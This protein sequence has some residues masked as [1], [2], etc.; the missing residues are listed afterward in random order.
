[1]AEVGKRVSDGR[2]QKLIEAFLTANIMDGLAQWTPAP[3]APQGAVLS[4]LLSNIYLD[5]LDH[6]MAAAGAEMVRYA[7]DFVILCKSKEQ[8]EAALGA[9]REWTGRAGP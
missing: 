5:P 3:G 1:M 4:P 7:D 6:L 9:V 2:V 8:A